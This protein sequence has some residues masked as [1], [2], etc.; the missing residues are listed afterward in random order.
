MRFEDPSK[1]GTNE[2]KRHPWQIHGT[3]YLQGLHAPYNI[4]QKGG[5]NHKTQ[6]IHQSSYNPT[7]KIVKPHL[8]VSK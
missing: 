8:I 2:I 6:F 3:P 5:P 4:W 7:I 1:I